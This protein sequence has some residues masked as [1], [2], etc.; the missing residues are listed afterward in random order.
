V[1]R[2]VSHVLVG[3]FVTRMMVGKG[4]LVKR[5]WQLRI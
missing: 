5:V 2:C 3:L 4:L 1:F